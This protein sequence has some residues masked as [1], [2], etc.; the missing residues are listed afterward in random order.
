[1]AICA[2]IQKFEVRFADPQYMTRADGAN[3]IAEMLTT[4]PKHGLPVK[5]VKR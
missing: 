3:L 5:L 4:R 2:L 1:M